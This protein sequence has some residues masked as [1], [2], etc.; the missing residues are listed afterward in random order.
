MKIE[1]RAADWRTPFEPESR[2]LLHS[3]SLVD[4]W[5]LTPFQRV[6]R[7]TS[8]GFSPDSFSLLDRFHDTAGTSSLRSIVMRYERVYHD[9]TRQRTTM[10]V[11]TRIFRKEDLDSSGGIYHISPKN[12]DLCDRGNGESRGLFRSASLS[13]WRPFNVSI[14]LDSPDSSSF[15]E[16]TQGCAFA[17][18]RG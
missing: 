11:L 2:G 8:F 7:E 6:K 16:C 9:A 15:A 12:S 18:T 4:V 17:E 5:Q 14:P 3:T 10:I 1:I 13:S